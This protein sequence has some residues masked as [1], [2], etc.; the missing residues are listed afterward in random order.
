MSDDLVP[1]W[2][3]YLGEFRRSGLA[4]EV[5]QWGWTL[6]FQNKCALLS[7]FSRPLAC[8]SNVSS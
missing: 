7:L 1:S 2:R 8:D 3:Y 6:R 4:E 5:G